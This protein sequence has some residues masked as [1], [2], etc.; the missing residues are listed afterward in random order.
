M[1]DLYKNT[2]NMLFRYGF[3][4]CHNID[5]RVVHHYLKLM[6]SKLVS[7]FL[8]MEPGFWHHVNVKKI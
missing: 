8:Y 6:W 1:L 4:K 5:C 7:I 2:K 3:E